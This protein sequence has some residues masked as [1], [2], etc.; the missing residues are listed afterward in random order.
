MQEVYPLQ[1][2]IRM[3]D[4]KDIRELALIG[5]CSAGLNASLIAGILTGQSIYFVFV[6]A[7]TGILTIHIW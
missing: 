6:L 5:M 1:G 2:V 4:Q 7:L 3:L